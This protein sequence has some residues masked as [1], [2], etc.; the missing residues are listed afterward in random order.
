L[1]GYAFGLLRWWRWLES[2]GRFWQA[3]TRSDGRDYVL[4]L[5]QALKPRQHPGTRSLATVGS[6][7]PVTRKPYLGD[8]YAPATVRHAIAVV[9]GF[10][11]F[12]MDQGEGPV[13]NPMPRRGSRP[14]AHHHPLDGFRSDGLRYSPRVPKRHPRALSDDQWCG[15]F[16]VLGS[17]RDRALSSLAVCNGARAGEV[18]GVRLVDIDWGD[19]LIR[20]DRKASRAEQWLPASPEALVWTRLYLAAFP[21]LPTDVPIWLTNRRFGSG[22]VLGRRTMSYIRG[23]NP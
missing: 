23:A 12:W 19:Q 5:Q 7:N 6:A 11:Q 22:E 16:A 1:R 13:L 15:L 18:L 4:M 20:V 14:N 10:Y 9:H 8:G 2:R 3:V 21:N 17:D